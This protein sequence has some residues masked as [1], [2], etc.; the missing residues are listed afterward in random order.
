MGYASYGHVCGL[1][2]C[3]CRLCVFVS[4]CMCGLC[5]DYV[6][7]WPNQCKMRCQ[8]SLE[9]VSWMME[10]VCELDDGDCDLDDGNCL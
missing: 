5:V 2:A 1:C 7:S 4:V 8:L 10:T 9:T 3:L 6:L